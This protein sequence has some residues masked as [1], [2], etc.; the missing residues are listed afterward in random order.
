MDL[1]MNRGID[2]YLAEAMTRVSM[3]LG[4]AFQVCK[5]H[6]DGTALVGTDLQIFADFSKA[7]KKYTSGLDTFA[8][9][10]AVLEIQAA[11]AALKTKAARARAALEKEGGGEVE[12]LEGG[13]LEEGGEDEKRLVNVDV[14]VVMERMWA[15]LRDGQE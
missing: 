10:E 5:R 3:R 11:E 1:A 13:E 9:I 7:W 8:A 14:G 12:P 2:V 6:A 4:E 15:R